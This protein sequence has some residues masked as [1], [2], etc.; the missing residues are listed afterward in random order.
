MTADE[1]EAQLKK[2]G[3]FIPKRNLE[4]LNQELAKVAADNLKKIAKD[5]AARLS[6]TQVKTLR[7]LGLSQEEIADVEPESNPFRDYEI[8]GAQD[9]TDLLEK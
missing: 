3:L 9:V 4:Q 8:S 5:N 2:M 1:R 7:K 6:S